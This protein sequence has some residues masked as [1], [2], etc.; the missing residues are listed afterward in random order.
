MWYSNGYLPVR[1]MQE[2]VKDALRRAEQARMLREA[3]GPRT[4]QRRR[5]VALHLKNLLLTLSSRRI[6]DPRSPSRSAGSSIASALDERGANRGLLV[7]YSGT[8]KGE[9]LAQERC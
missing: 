6:G 1:I 7:P 3:A 9:C 5:N 4:P 8:S 2:R